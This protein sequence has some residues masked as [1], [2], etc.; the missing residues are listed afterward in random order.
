MSIWDEY[1]WNC[2]I[3]LI[4]R[5]Y[6]LLSSEFFRMLMTATWHHKAQ[7][8]KPRSFLSW[9]TESFSAG[10]MMP[11][12]MVLAIRTIMLICI[13]TALNGW[14]EIRPTWFISFREIGV[15]FPWCQKRAL[16]RDWMCAYFVL[17]FRKNWQTL[18]FCLWKGWGQC[19]IGGQ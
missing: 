8:V 14:I 17:T 2:K 19:A 12:S 6:L 13:V 11:T 16:W 18:I 10:Y 4:C 5:T 7:V 1:T 3:K 15:A 9:M